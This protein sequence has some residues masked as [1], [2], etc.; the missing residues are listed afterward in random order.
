MLLHERLQ[1]LEQQIEAL[2][3]VNPSEE[4]HER[5]VGSHAEPI[6]EASGRVPLGQAVRVERQRQ[7]PDRLLAR[8]E[9]PK[10][11]SLVLG[12][13]QQQ[14]GVCKHRPHEGEV[15]DTLHD[16]PQPGGAR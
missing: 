8:P 7:Q 14:R 1:R 15:V 10:Q 6:P 13:R 4:E 2:E 12:L 9:R 11:G 5:G 16:P 3:A